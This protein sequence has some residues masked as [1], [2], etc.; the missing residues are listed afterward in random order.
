MMC[1]QWLGGVVSW[2]R[3]NVAYMAQQS[4]P[5]GGLVWD[6]AAQRGVANE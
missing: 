2:A 6:L 5:W 1:L 4:C 3:N